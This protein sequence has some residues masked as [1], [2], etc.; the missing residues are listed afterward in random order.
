MEIKRIKRFEISMDNAF[1]QKFAYHIYQYLAGADAYRKILFVGKYDEILKIFLS[2][3]EYI[4]IVSIDMES[5]VYRGYADE[6]IIEIDSDL[7]VS[8]YRA[9]TDEGYLLELEAD[10]AFVMDDCNIEI[11]SSLSNCSLICECKLS[12]DTLSTFVNF[13]WR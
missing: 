13:A 3:S 7:M 12:Y 6:F 1:L 9:K 10:L 11:L 4:N 8:C 5:E 2:L